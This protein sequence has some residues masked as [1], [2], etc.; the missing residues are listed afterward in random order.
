MEHVQA[1]DR[2][3]IVGR[4]SAY[5]M[6]VDVTRHALPNTNLAYG[7]SSPRRT[8]ARL[9]QLRS[10]GA[11]VRAV[12]PIDDVAAHARIRDLVL[13]GYAAIN[14]RMSVTVL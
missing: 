6:H 10:R 7:I 13:E 9:A 4:S 1:M 5:G 14:T 2:A 3:T 11:K 12:A 8:R